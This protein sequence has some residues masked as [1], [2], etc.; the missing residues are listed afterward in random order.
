MKNGGQ[1]RRPLTKEH[2][3]RM[4]I[5]WLEPWAPI[6]QPEVRETMESLHSELCASHPLFG[7]CVTAFARRRDQDDVLFALADGRV[8]EV[9]LTW[10][11]KPERDPRWPRTTI[12]ASACVWA[13]EQMRPLHEET[14]PLD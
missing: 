3:G 14:G 12:F 2:I 10:S 8:A 4:D 6:E 9:H 7:L 11:R 1:L 13:E 5:M